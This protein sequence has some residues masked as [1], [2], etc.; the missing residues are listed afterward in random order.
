MP[1]RHLP[2]RLL[3]LARCHQQ[4]IHHQGLRGEPSG[5]TEQ[6]RT[7]AAAPATAFPETAL[8]PSVAEAVAQWFP[9]PF[10]PRSLCP[11]PRRTTTQYRST[12]LIRNAH[13]PRIVIRP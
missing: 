10:Q 6:P 9:T 13:P 11:T 7:P 2:I 5:S 8:P 1:T 3:S 4:P 12:Y